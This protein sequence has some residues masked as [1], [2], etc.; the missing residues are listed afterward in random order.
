MHDCSAMCD[1]TAL[2]GAAQ[3]ELDPHNGVGVVRRRNITIK[4][5]LTQYTALINTFLIYTRSICYSRLSPAK[6]TVSSVMNN[7]TDLLFLKLY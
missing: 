1:K 5:F 4:V 7:S 6:K 3:D 2:C